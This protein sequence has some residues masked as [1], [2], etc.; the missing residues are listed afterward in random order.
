MEKWRKMSGICKTLYTIV[1]PNVW[2]VGT[3]EGEEV[4]VKGKEYFN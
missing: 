3:E 1:M 4:H 2:I